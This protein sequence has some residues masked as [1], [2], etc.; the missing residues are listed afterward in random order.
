MAFDK[1]KISIDELRVEADEAIDEALRYEK[2]A[3]VAVMD[4]R[5]YWGLWEMKLAAVAETE[6]RLEELE[7]RARG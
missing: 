2:L 3:R 7:E 1:L 5:K 4:A 6:A